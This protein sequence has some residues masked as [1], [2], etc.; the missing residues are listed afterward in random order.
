MSMDLCLPAFTSSGESLLETSTSQVFVS[1]HFLHRSAVH[2][3][4]DKCSFQACA[5]NWSI[6]PWDIVVF[7]F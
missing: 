4:L 7:I 6:S 5:W 3:V 1:S 2:V